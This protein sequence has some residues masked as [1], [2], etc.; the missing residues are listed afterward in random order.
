MQCL[1]TGVNHKGEGVARIDGK[2]TFVP[3]AIPGE[4]VE[5]S[6]TSQKKKF[7]QAYLERVM[8]PS[9][10]RVVPSC[11]YFPA[12]GGCAYQHVSYDR[13]L[14]LK[15]EVVQNSLQRIAALEVEV[16]PVIGMEPP[17][18][19]RN[20]V[21]WHTGREFGQPSLGYYRQGSH[22]LMGIDDCSLIS[23]EMQ[24]YS[25]YIKDH[26]Q[27]F[28]VPEGCQ[29]MLRQSAASRDIMIIFVGPGSS[30]MQFDS[31][32]E[33]KATVVSVDQGITRLHYGRPTLTETV[34]DLKLEIAPLAF[35][36]VNHRQMEKML[37]LIR[38][39]ACLQPDDTILDAYC[40]IG[41]IAL[42]LA[43]EVRRVVGVESFKDSIKS[44]KRNAYHN[45]INNCQFI[46]GACEKI[47]PE[48]E[49]S[50]DVIILDPPR[51]GCKPEL[52]QAVIRKSP[53]C[54]IYVSCNPATLA[55]DLA[56]FNEAHFKV[57]KVQPLDMFPQT[58]HVETVV[59]MSRVE[60]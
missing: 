34:A 49:E 13:Q 14:Q 23:R 27:E 29:V 42:V 3:L 39:Y 45:G 35:M 59:L 10:D 12:C 26:L 5:I 47:V 50:F 1:I 51:A 44:A 19:Y 55:R 48:L 15:R 8:N 58:S 16:N 6:I 22:R 52:I 43:G 54:I 60:K 4:T 9:P 56:I 46:K 40:G 31:L 37:E 57:D 38:Y 24:E 21:I 30:G 36:Q 18:H 53:R 32:N 2:V 17:W 25:R 11:P 20:K 7:Q 41:T 28:Q 33:G